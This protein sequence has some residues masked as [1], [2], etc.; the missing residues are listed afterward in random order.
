MTRVFLTVLLNRGHS[1]VASVRSQAK[2]DQIRRGYPEVPLSRL[3]FVVVD[4]F[5]RE[6]AFEEA[7]TTTPPFEAVIHTASPF[8]L[9]PGS[10]DRDVLEPAVLGTTRL[11]EAVQAHV[12]SVRRVVITSSFFA[13]AK[14]AESTYLYS[15]ADWNSLTDEQI[16]SNP[17]FAYIGSKIAAE[18]AAWDFIE[19][20]NPSFTLT[21]I[22]PVLVFGPIIHD[23]VSLEEVNVSAH[24]VRD[25][26]TGEYKNEIP[27]SQLSRWVDV[28][29]SA[30]A[31]VRAIE[32]DEAGGK[33]F[34]AS[35]GTYSN[36]EVANILW[37]HFP[38]LRHKLPGPEVKS[39]GYPAAGVSKCDT[40]LSRKILGV[41]YMSLED[42]IVSMAGSLVGLYQPEFEV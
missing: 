31:H 15:D 27:E 37:K 38:A 16:Q 25:L 4:D 20:Q 34:F 39:G 26:I 1:V 11:L 41:E 33:R 40:E 10:I 35:G 9:Q 13:A 22:L 42:S 36:R 2:A 28:R 17:V 5:I 32:V 29:D 23:V 7:L 30:L 6:H 14:P 19:K 12:P 18:K 3:D 8:Q 24:L 21:T